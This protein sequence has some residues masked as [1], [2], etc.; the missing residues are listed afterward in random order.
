MIWLQ[1]LKKGIALFTGN[2]IGYGSHYSVVMLLDNRDQEV[3]IIIIII[4]S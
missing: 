4:I 2:S 1:L 3:I